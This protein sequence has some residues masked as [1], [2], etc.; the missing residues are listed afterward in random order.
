MILLASV[1]EHG[2]PRPE[3]AA[4]VVE[5]P[6]NSSCPERLVRFGNALAP[7]AKETIISL[8]Q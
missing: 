7:S 1:E 5:V 6:L 3:P 4:E 2:R 8:L